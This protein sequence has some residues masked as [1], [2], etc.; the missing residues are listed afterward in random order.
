MDVSTPLVRLDILGKDFCQRVAEIT[1]A[2]NKK[3]RPKW[4]V[5]FQ[6]FKEQRGLLEDRRYVVALEE[7]PPSN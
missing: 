3:W 7:I 1:T 4:I 6:V 5:R 2:D